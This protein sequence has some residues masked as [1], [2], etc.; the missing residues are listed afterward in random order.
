VHEPGC[1]VRAAVDAG[2]LDAERY[3]SYRRLWEQGA[4]SMGRIWKDLVSSRST[5]GEGEFRL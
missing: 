1:S 4:G 3:D 2:E 5:V